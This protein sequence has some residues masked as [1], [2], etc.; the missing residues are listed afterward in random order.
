VDHSLYLEAKTFL[1]GL[2]VV[3]DKLSMAHSL[4]NRV[5]LLDNDLVEFAQRLPVEMKLRDLQ[6]VV[7]LNENVPGP[8]TEA[9][10]HDTRDGKLLLRKV[11][12]RY[13][14]DEITNQVKR[15]FSGPD[16][17]WFRGDSID[18][19]RRVLLSPDAAIY[20]FLDPAGVQ[21]LISEHLEGRENRRLLL[22]SLLSFEQWCRIFL[23]G[24]RP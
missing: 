20:E 1:H 11:M 6:H 7:E 13:V 19:V 23:G 15:G 3:E 21:P 4:E 5:P 18:Y 14:P 17:S 2:F 10:F 9:Y 16:A 12:G 8:K 22:W 24:E